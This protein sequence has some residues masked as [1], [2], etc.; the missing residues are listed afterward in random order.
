MKLNLIKSF[1]LVAFF[2]W[3][4]VAAVVMTNSDNIYIENLLREY[5][6]YPAFINCM[7]NDW[8]I[9]DSLWKRSY[10]NAWCLNGYAIIVIHTIWVYLNPSST[11]HLKNLSKIKLFSFGCLSLLAFVMFYLEW[12]FRPAIKSSEKIRFF[13]LSDF[14]LLFIFPAVWLTISILLFSGIVF[15]FSIYKYHRV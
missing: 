3:P 8:L 13:F 15:F 10:V 6:Y 2:A 5:F 1:L 11:S 7:T 4:G 9:N 12:I 14:G